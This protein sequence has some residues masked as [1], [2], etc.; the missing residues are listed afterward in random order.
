[1]GEELFGEDR[2]LA[3]LQDVAGPNR[4]RDD[5]GRAGSGSA[6]RRRREAVRRHHRGIGPLPWQ[7]PHAPAFELIDAAHELHRSLND[8]GLRLGRLKDLMHRP[9]YVGLHGSRISSSGASSGGRSRRPGRMLSSSSAM[10]AGSCAPCL[11]ARAALT[12]PQPSWPSTT[13]RG[14]RRCTPAYCSVPITSGEITLPATRAMNSSP[15]P[16]SKI[17]SGGTRESLQPMR[18]AYGR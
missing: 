4:A 10:R 17:N 18:V 1:M 14:V 13:K 3:H 12:A 6:A 2:L 8:T 7:E 5:D 16:A 11:A 15:K 9:A